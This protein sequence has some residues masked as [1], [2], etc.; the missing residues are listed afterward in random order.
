MRASEMIATASVIKA[1]TNIPPI[2]FT[3]PLSF[4]VGPG[5]RSQHFKEH[6]YFV[7]I[8]LVLAPFDPREPKLSNARAR[9]AAVGAL[10]HF[11]SSSSL[12]A[13]RVGDVQGVARRTLSIDSDET[14]ASA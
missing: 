10:V 9:A 4:C 6:L 11:A 13:R 3:W 12:R 2:Q 5:V 8:S 14:K 1:A 7:S